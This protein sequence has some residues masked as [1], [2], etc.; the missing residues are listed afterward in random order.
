MDPNRR[1]EESYFPNDEEAAIA[2]NDYHKLI[3]TY[4]LDLFMLNSPFRQ[5]LIIDM[6]GQTH[7]ENW[8]ELGYLL[9]PSDLSKELSTFCKKKSSIR[10][11][12]EESKESL[13]DLVR[14]KLFQALKK[15]KKK[16]LVADMCF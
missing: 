11:L 6:H 12:S 3:E 2:F 4:F 10:L 9:T 16:H 7:K 8:I 14:G 13:E 1:A 15:K 5:G